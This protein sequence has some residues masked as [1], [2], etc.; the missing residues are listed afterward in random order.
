MSGNAFYGVVAMSQYQTDITKS[1]F[2]GEKNETKASK[3]NSFGIGARL[4]SKLCYTLSIDYESVA[5]DVFYS[6]IL[7]NALCFIDN[8]I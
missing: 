7:L 6:I 4:K 3:T 8:T 2:E 5:Q 1:I